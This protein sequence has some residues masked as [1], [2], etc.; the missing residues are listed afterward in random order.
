M[1][2]SNLFMM[3]LLS[4]VAFTSCTDNDD[5]SVWEDTGNVVFN[6]QIRGV[7]S[8]VND[9]SWDNGD[10][11]GI[12]MQTGSVEVANKKYTAQTNGTLTAAAGNELRYPAEGTS[13]FLAY[14][15]FSSSLNGKTV[16][17]SVADQANPSKIDFLYSN[18]ATGI[19]SG[20]TVNLAFAHQLSNIVVNIS[21]DET[22]SSTKGISL[23]LTGMNTSASFN[24]ADGKL[25]A[26]DSK[27]TIN[28]N[29]NTEGTQAQAIVLPAA[30][31]GVNMT[32]KLNGMS[33]DH[34]LKAPDAKGFEAGYKY[35]YNATLSIFNGQPSIKLGN[36]TI[37][38]WTD[39]AGGNIDVDFEGGDDKPVTGDVLLEE[40]FDVN[41]GAFTI[42]NIALPEGSDYVWKHDTF[43]N[44][45][46]IV[47]PL[48]F[49][50]ASAF[51]GKKCASEAWLVS[52]VLQL[53]TDKVAT[54]TFHHCHKFSSDKAKELTLLVAEAGTKVTAEATGWAQVTIPTYG[55]GNDYKY[56][57][58]SVDLAAYKGKKIQFAY[59]Y[60]STTESAS[61]WQISDVKVS[62]GEGG[63]TP[64]PD[65]DPEPDPEPTPDEDGTLFNE[66]FGD[67]VKDGKFWPSVDKYTGW[68]DTHKMT[69][70]DP[71]MT[72][73]YSNASV[74]STSTMNGHVWFASGK[75]SALRIAGFKTS[76]FAK[77]TLSYDIAANAVGEQSVI[78]VSTDKG[79]V[80]VPAAAI[81]QQNKFQSVTV[82]LPKDFTWIQFTST[83]AT[84]EVGYRVDNVKI[85]GNK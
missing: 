66:T 15:P 85:V 4:T 59:R 78:K 58:A 16:T 52:P 35:T 79:D 7:Q 67:P 40:N 47:P 20:E 80:T 83:A 24:L 74:R 33:F 10:E 39:K 9:A 38:D 30:A 71:V 72:G 76:N 51:V 18:N 61:T 75:E 27:A 81:S 11:I 6:S 63:D 56:E 55:S 48:T 42:T 70:S 17:V 43:D 49:M 32:F 65:P 31:E 26:T 34:A 3:G 54:L 64:N 68:T 44:K 82:T 14:Y 5:N 84:N 8:R 41:Q 60:I 62:T 19:K 77:I 12:F 21:G 46:Q 2:I 36:A 50:K 22:I 53:P 37:T 28:M 57:L 69:Y 29:V 45:G 23:S 73:S 25:T 1:K 13:S